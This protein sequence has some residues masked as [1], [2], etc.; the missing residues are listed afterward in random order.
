MMAAANKAATASIGRR[1]P[2]P[3]AGAASRS[4]GTEKRALAIVSLEAV[5]VLVLTVAQA[6][7]PAYFS[8]SAQA[9][10]PNFF[11]HSS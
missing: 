10:S 4:S 5:M 6:S 7:L 11:F 2:P 1:N 9:S 3:G 8:S